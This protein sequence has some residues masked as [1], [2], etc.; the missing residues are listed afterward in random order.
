MPTAIPLATYRL[1]LSSKFGFDDAAELVSYLKAL[2]ISHVYASP[3]LRAR[4]GSTHG[5]D[6]VDHNQLDPQL[7]GEQAFERLSAALAGADLG[8]ILDF[9]P[10]HVGIAGSENAWW[11]DVLEWGRSSPHA[12]SF[13]ID[14]DAPDARGRVLLPVL[15]REYGDVLRAG[16]IRLVFDAAQGLFSFQYHQQRFPVRPDLY[17]HIIRAIARQQPASVAQGLLEITRTNSA[18]SRDD[19][20]AL[21][22]ALRSCA[23]GEA[24]SGLLGSYQP[25][26]EEKRGVRPLDHLLER[27]HYRLADWRIVN[28]EINY[29]RFFNIN[30]LAGLR[31]E[32]PR[33]FAAVHALVGKLV[34]RGELHGLRLD[35]IDGLADP[36]GYCR[37]LRDFIAARREPEASPFYVVVEKI[38]AEGEELPEFPGVA[39]TTGYE[40]LNLISRLLVDTGGLEPLD[41]YARK[42]SGQ[43][44][45]PHVLAHSRMIVLD[46]TFQSELDRAA[47]L[48]VRVAAGHWESRDLQRA[49]LFRAL[50]LYVLKFP[51]YRTYVR[52][53]GAWVEDRETIRRTIE[54]AR[55]AEPRL[56]R[57][58]RFLERALTLDLIASRE[59]GYSRRRARR[60]T[61]L[62][63]QLTAPV[64]AKSLEDT[65][66]YRY[67]RLLALNEVGNDPALPGVSVDE[68]H[69]R[70]AERARTLPH[71]MTA[72]ATHDTKRGEDARARLLALSEL[73]EEWIDHVERWEA[74]NASLVDALRGKP[75]P[76]ANH[77]YLIYQSLIGAWPFAEPDQMFVKRMQEFAVKAAREGKVETRWRAP[78]QDYE[79]RLTAFVRGLLE[80]PGFVQSFDAFA[81]R[82]ALIGALNALAQVAL[83][84]TIPGV[85]DFFQGTEFWDLSLVDPDNR[86]AVDFALREAALDARNDWP[87]LARNW[88]DGRIKLALIRHLLAIRN[89]FAALFQA[90]DYR[91]LRVRGPDAEHVVAFARSDQGEAAIVVVG[92]HFGRLSGGGRRWPDHYAWRAAICATGLGS[93]RDLLTPDHIIADGEIAVSHLF[94]SLPVAVLHAVA[95]N[96]E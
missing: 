44:A 25:R 40:W 36:I 91:Q 1:Q 75:A 84:I 85:P 68:F 72:T 4:A 69:R 6:V 64:M 94:R 76:S 47:R 45:F 14:W 38:L 11:T 56:G 74:E 35:H 61:E 27:Q 82:T 34:G 66:F 59:S 19:A 81:Q 16:E 93:L 41:R 67:L 88:S 78:A 73:A 17:P 53:A 71:G 22:Q 87:T 29:R 42:L 18:R 63:Q 23:A 89:R 37:S 28:G 13:D 95:Q 58:F 20:A 83:K 49:D 96:R 43:D 12:A 79:A 60:F 32:E 46:S 51:F 39:G 10:N 70:M 2:G 8:L 5:Y 80:R 3:F 62:V 57:A 26:P 92:R 15:G 7:G 30:D 86:R 9:V 48:L 65:A 54:A 90:G 21:K 52:G 33:T 31:V 50:R 24:I 77:R 55:S